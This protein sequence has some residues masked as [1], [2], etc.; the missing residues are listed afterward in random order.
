MA[1]AAAG[2]WVALVGACLAAAE[3]PPDPPPPVGLD[4]LLKLPGG[5]LP[6]GS[7]PS[8]ASPDREMWEGRF[9]EVRLALQE[10]KTRLSQSQA[11]LERLAAKSDAWQVAAPG[12]Q[13][14]QNSQ[15][16]P[17]SYRLRQEIRGHREE[18]EQQQKRLRDLE[19]EASLAGVP[20][21]WR[22]PVH[23]DA[24]PES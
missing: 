24:V 23:E 13:P 7:A 17:L 6:P 4:K 21:E 9:R 11:E 8:G 22:R 10:A 5:P 12:A 1:W 19:V 3:P 2:A 15:N 14:G 18:V 20:A 16:S